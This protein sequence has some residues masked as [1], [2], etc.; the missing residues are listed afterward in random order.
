MSNEVWRGSD[1][2]LA[3]REITVFGIEDDA[4]R[5]L[6]WRSSDI[7]YSRQTVAAV[8]VA[9]RVEEFVDTLGAVLAR[10]PAVM[11]GF[12]IDNIT[13]AAEVSAKGKLALLGTGGELGG[14]G[15]L[16]FTFRRRGSDREGG[17]F[18][19]GAAD[20][21]DG[22]KNAQDGKEADPNVRR[23]TADRPARAD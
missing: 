14:K 12:E 10:L 7:R 3:N 1:G 15:G 23:D 6:F 11:S 8:D 17:E 21:E 5:S 19:T 9:R 2:E 20:N 13:V 4:D 18:T 22:Q 16:T